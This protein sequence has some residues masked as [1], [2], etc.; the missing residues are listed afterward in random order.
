MYKSRRKNLI[1]RIFSLT[2]ALAVMGV[3]FFFSSQKGSSSDNISISFTSLLFTHEWDSAVI[4]N[5]LIRK[6]AHAVEY[7]A[8]SVPVYFF[9]ST[10]KISV[11]MRCTASFGFSAFY[12]VT[13][14]I[15]QLF[16]EGRTC[17]LRD[18]LIDSLGAFLAVYFLNLIVKRVIRGRNKPDSVSSAAANAVFETARAFMCGEKTAVSEIDDSNYRE[19]LLKLREHKLL[20]VASYVLSDDTKISESNRKS[21]KDE[22]FAQIISQENE[23]DVFFKAYKAMLKA[24]ANPITLKGCVCASLWREPSLRIS[25]DADILAGSNDFSVCRKV[26]EALGYRSSEY[27]SSNEICFTNKKSRIELHSLPFPDDASTS[28]L[29][30]VVGDLCEKTSSVNIDGVEIRCPDVQNHLIYLVLHAFKHFIKSGVGIRQLMDISLFSSDESIDWN[31]VFEKCSE[32]SADGFLSAVLLIAE[33]YF[34]LD[35]SGIDSPAFDKSV[36]C[37]I[38]LDDIK[39]GG[40]YGPRNMNKHHSSSITLN[41]YS[42][43]QS[44]ERNAVIF[45][46]IDRMKKR[47]PYLRKFPFLL[48]AAWMQRIFGYIFSDHN[49]SETLASGKSRIRIMKYYGIIK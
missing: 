16:V 15:H 21:L 40:I 20:P 34:G 29:N 44:G 2:A 8:L 19:F 5:S 10:F 9:F 33:K 48:P 23:S 35:I 43:S 39:P 24:G 49:V 45:L 42:K 41:G 17:L 36:D 3:I 13:D 46:P 12:S 30:S 37:E 7:A 32:V 22:A 14:E 38:L 6:F 27:E 28:K 11:P 25:G 47:Y 26:L 4:L 1:I 31:T 18:I